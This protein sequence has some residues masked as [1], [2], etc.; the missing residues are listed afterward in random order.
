MKDFFLSSEDTF[1][2]KERNR[3]GLD[4]A[5]RRSDAPTR[6]EGKRGL[7]FYARL[8]GDDARAR[9][10]SGG[11]RFK[12]KS[13]HSAASR[14]SA[15]FALSSP[16]SLKKKCPSLDVALMTPVVHEPS[17]A[18]T[19]TLRV[20][21]GGGGGNRADNSSRARRAHTPRGPLGV[22]SATLRE[23]RLRARSSRAEH[24]ARRTHQAA[25][26]ETEASPPTHRVRDRIPSE[27]VVRG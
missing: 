9:A 22:P 13:L 2:V 6:S 12:S 7:V 4:R 24:L 17:I 8:L 5:R 27:R 25:A 15:S 20:F 11:A 3:S 23:K 18:P 26:S 14:A 1:S 16:F 19:K 21:P 10:G